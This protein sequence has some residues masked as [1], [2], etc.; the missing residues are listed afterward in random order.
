MVG[1]KRI[2]GEHYRWRVSPRLIAKIPKELIDQFVSGPM[3]AAAI[4]DIGRF[5]KGTNRAGIG[6]RA[7]LSPWLSSGRAASRG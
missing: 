2:W 6:S 7:W 5:Q 4:Q 1:H 3:T